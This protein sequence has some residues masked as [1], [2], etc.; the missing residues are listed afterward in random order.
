MYIRVGI[1]N[2]ADTVMLASAIAS[3]LSEGKTADEIDKIA[4]LLG[5]VVT[6]M[7]TIAFFKKGGQDISVPPL[8]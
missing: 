7:E 8:I 4:D 1:V 5:Q 2:P 3:A 6:T